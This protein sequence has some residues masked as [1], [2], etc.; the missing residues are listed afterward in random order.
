MI[1]VHESV[2]PHC[3]VQERLGGY[4]AAMQ[5][6]SLPDARAGPR[7]RRDGDRRA[8]P[9]QGPADGRDLLQRFGIDAARARLVASRR[10]DSRRR[11]PDRLQRRV[12]HAVHDAAADDGRLRC[13]EDR[14]S[15]RASSCSR[16]PTQTANGKAADGGDDPS[17]PDRPRLDGAGEERRSRLSGHAAQLRAARIAVDRFYR[18]CRL[19]GRPTCAASAVVDYLCLAQVFTRNALDQHHE[20]QAYRHSH[21]RRRLPRTQR[22][23]SRRGEDLLG[24]GLR[25]HRISQGLR[26]AVRSRAV[27]H[28]HAAE[29]DRHSQPRR[30]D[31]RLD[32]QGPLRRDAS[33]CTTA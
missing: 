1:F 3:S 20:Q 10:D 5:E 15:G 25:L 31:P 6:A 27:R 19:R 33:A 14:R 8:G 2:K 7:R 28:A 13:R 16:I 21:Q 18:S 24:T 32:E 22:R 4:R 29:H 12:R 30:H 9:R 23:D 26:R 11:E 17:E